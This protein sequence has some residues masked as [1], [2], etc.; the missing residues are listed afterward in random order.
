MTQQ[1]IAQ[2]NK[3]KQQ[4][5][6]PQRKKS[7]RDTKVYSE[8]V[9]L[10]ASQ[11]MKLASPSFLLLHALVVFLLLLVGLSDALVPQLP[12]PNNNPTT[13]TNSKDSK[14][15]VNTGILCSDNKVPRELVEALD[16]KPLM[17]NVAQHAGTKR[18]RDALLSTVEYGSFQKKKSFHSEFNRKAILFSVSPDTTTA[19]T[20][21]SRSATSAKTTSTK[22]IFKMADTLVEAKKE[23][24][25]VSE[26]ME[27]LEKDIPSASSSESANLSSLP[28]PPIYGVDSSPWSSNF[29]ADSDDDEW[30]TVVLAG[31]PMEPLDL[32]QILQAEMVVTRI[33]ACCEWARLKE[34]QERA[35]NIIQIFK[36]VDL[37]VLKNLQN[38]LEGAVVIIRG[39]KSVFDPTGAKVRALW[40]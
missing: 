12:L 20:A 34:I 33:A 36:R 27:L 37:D 16:L 13:T 39:G 28:L 17:Q 26:A 30:L 3:T 2:Q 18:A 14:Q 22:H 23:W 9:L 6:Y 10:I 35:P 19:T 40:H 38:E 25:L 8:Y 21:S 1:N 31:Y 29:S 5:A 15:Q 24:D 11:N 4:Q 32:E 7:V